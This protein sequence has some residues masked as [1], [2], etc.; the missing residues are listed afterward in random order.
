MTGWSHAA[1][2]EQADESAAPQNST[3]HWFMADH[4]LGNAALTTHKPGLRSKITNKCQ[5]FDNKGKTQAR[6]PLKVENT[7]GT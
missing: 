3:V 7:K 2:D 4:W 6:Q 1:A 5:E